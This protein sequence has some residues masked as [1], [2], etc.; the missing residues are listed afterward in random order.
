[1]RDRAG[2]RRLCSNGERLE[3]LAPRLLATAAE[4]FAQLPN[5]EPGAGND[6]MLVR[7]LFGLAKHIPPEAAVEVRMRVRVCVPP[8]RV[9]ACLVLMPFRGQEVALA[10][11]AGDGLGHQAEPAP[12]CWLG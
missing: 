2:A 7:S 11:T 12:V 5:L 10:W 6:D 9:F 1:M 3:E 8:A 4:Q